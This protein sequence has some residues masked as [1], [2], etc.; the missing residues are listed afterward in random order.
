MTTC[1]GMEVGDV[2]PPGQY[3]VSNVDGSSDDDGSKAR[4]WSKRTGCDF[5][6]QKCGILGCGSD[7]EVGGH[8]WVKRLSK[9][10]F[11]LPICQSHNKDPELTKK[12]KLTKKDVKLVARNR[13]PNMK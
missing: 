12:Y 2:L 11:I 6:K 7:A 9:F 8:M 4:F 1:E 5:Y 10:C 3:E 13:T